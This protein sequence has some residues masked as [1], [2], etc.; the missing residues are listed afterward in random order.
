MRTIGLAVP[1]RNPPALAKA[2]LDALR[3]D[4]RT[5]ELA[6][7]GEALARECFDVQKTAAQVLTIYENILCSLGPATRVSAC[8]ACREGRA[9]E[10]LRT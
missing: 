7:N 5:M 6:R 10:G 9:D 4:D 2:I 3:D 8:I 1:S